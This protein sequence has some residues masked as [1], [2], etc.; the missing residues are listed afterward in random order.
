[1]F[2]A[3]VHGCSSFSELLGDDGS[4]LPEVDI[5]PKEDISAL[6]YSSGTTG[7]PKGVAVTHYNFVA[8]VFQLRS[9]IEFNL[10]RSI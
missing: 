10:H 9:F 8:A 5:N 1:M 7:L 6:P 4:A 2:G 3:A